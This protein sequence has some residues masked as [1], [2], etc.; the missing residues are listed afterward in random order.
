MGKLTSG[1]VDM[2]NAVVTGS[3][4]ATGQSASFQLGTRDSEFNVSARG[5]FVGTIRLE[6]TFDGGTNWHPLTVGGSPIMTFTA[7]FSEGWEEIENGVLYRLN[8]TAYTSG[9]ITYR[10]SQ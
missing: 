9:T 7:P 2:A 1:S 8:C 10:I 6:R 5:T 4:T 3:F